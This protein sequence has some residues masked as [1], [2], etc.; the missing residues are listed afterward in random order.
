MENW[1]LASV[2]SQQLTLGSP[3]RSGGGFPPR[4]P[5]TIPS[6][7]RPGVPPGPPAVPRRRGRRDASPP[8]NGMTAGQ[9]SDQGNYSTEVDE[10]Q[11]ILT[12]FPGPGGPPPRWGRGAARG[13]SQLVMQLQQLHQHVVPPPRLLLVGLALK[14]GQAGHLV[15]DLAVHHLAEAIRIAGGVGQVGEDCLGGLGKLLHTM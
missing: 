14:A 3:S 2:L 9:P 11:G 1:G 6:P 13:R 15:L 4:L 5:D 12:D 10:T 7:A 8:E